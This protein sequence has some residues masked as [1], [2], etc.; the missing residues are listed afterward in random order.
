MLGNG[1]CLMNWELVA[2]P[3][4]RRRSADLSDA[5]TLQILLPNF[6]VEHDFFVLEQNQDVGA[7]EHEVAEFFA[8]L[9][10][11]ATSGVRLAEEMRPIPI[12]STATKPTSGES[13][14]I[15][16]RSWL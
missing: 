5:L 13:M 1:L 8:L 12:G 15:R 10:P 11:G 14:T 4:K 7:A 2:L 16:P 3:R 6:C 9:Q